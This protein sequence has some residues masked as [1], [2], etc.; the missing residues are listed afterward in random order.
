MYTINHSTPLKKTLS[1]L[2]VYVLLLDTM[3]PSIY[4][5]KT[6]S[7]PNPTLWISNHLSYTPEEE[8]VFQKEDIKTF[9][10]Q[11]SSQDLVNE[12]LLYSPHFLAS[13]ASSVQPEISGFSIG[14]SDEMVDKFTGDFSYSIPLVDVEGYPITLT[15]NSNVSMLDEASW[16]G[17]GWNLNVGSISRDMRGIPDDFNGTDIITREFSQRDVETT[18]SKNGGYVSVG[19]KIGENL[20]VGLG[21]SFLAGKYTDNYLGIGKTYDLNIGGS[22][23]YSIQSSAESGGLFLAPTIN[24]GMAYDSKNGIGSTFGFGLEAGYNNG[25]KSQ[26]SGSLSYN[27]S[28]HSRYGMTN[29]SLSVSGKLGKT[30][31]TSSTPVTISSSFTSTSNF[32]YGTQTSMPR[33]HLN[34]AT[35]SS[36][37]EL[38]IYAGLNVGVLQMR[39]GYLRQDYN[40]SSQILYHSGKKIFHPAYGYFHSGKRRSYSGSYFPMMDFNRGIENEYSEEMRNLP[41]SVQTHDVFYVNAKGINAVFR[42]MRSDYGTYYDPNSESTFNNDSQLYSDDDVSTLATGATFSIPLTIGFGI[43]YSSATM[44]AN[45]ASGNWNNGGNLLEFTSQSPSA[46]FDQPVYFK[47]MGGVAPVDMEPWNM[48]NGNTADYFDINVSGTQM[49]QDNFLKIKNSNVLSGALNAYHQKTYSDIYFK[50]N[51]AGEL[52]A[53]GMPAK[54]GSYFSVTLGTGGTSTQIKR[55]DPSVPQ[56]KA[57][58]ISLI[59]VVAPNGVSYEYGIPVYS[60][61]KEEVTFSCEGRPEL[62]ENTVPSGIVEYQNLDNSTNNNLGRAAYYDKTEFPAYSQA[63]L[64]TNVTSSDYVDLTDNG[65]TMDDPGNYYNF[66]HTRVYGPSNR[67]GTRFPI[68]GTNSSNKK[69]FYAKGA[70][71]STRDDLA[72]YTYQEGELWYT[73]AVESKNLIVEFHLEDRKDAYSAN[74]DGILDDS[75][76]MKLLSEIVVYN[77]TGLLSTDRIIL[78]TI[79]FYYDYSLCEKSPGNLNTYNGSGQPSGKLTLR[80]I[81]V[82]NGNSVENALSSIKFSY[83]SGDDNPDFS[84][85]DVDAWGQYKPNTVIKPN[86]QYPYSAQDRETADLGAKAWKLIAIHNPMGGRIEIDY[87]SDS[88]AYVQDRRAMRNFDVHRMTDLFDFLKIRKNGNWGG[89]YRSNGSDLMEKKFHHDYGNVANLL[90]KNGIPLLYGPLI[91][92]GIFNKKPT[93]LYNAVFGE[94]DIRMVPNNVIIFKLENPLVLSADDQVFADKYVADC[95]FRDTNDLSKGPIKEL[96]TKMYVKI[97]E[98]VYDLVPAMSTISSNYQMDIFN[99]Y[100]GGAIPE[101]FPPYGAMPGINGRYE[102]GYVVVDPVHT[103]KREEKDGTNKV[104][105]GTIA[106]NPMQLAALEYARAALVDKVYGSDPASEGDMSID[107]KVFYGNDM[108]K[109]MIEA[110]YCNTFDTD[111]SDY[112][113]LMRLNEPDYTKFGGGARVK[114]IR[115]FDNWEAISGEYDS[116][117]SWKYRYTEGDQRNEY[118][119]GVAAFEPMNMIDENPFNEWI[120]YTNIRKKFPDENK[121]IP[122][123]LAYQLF[124]KPVVGYSKVDVEFIEA[125]NYGK[126]TTLYYTARD[127]PTIS[128][129][130]TIDKSAKIK[131]NNIITGKVRDIYGITQGYVVE[132]NDFHGKLRTAEVFKKNLQNQYLPI[133]KT[134]YNY[135]GKGEQIKMADRSGKLGMH[136]AAIEY[137]I[138]ADSK[139]CT[140]E[141]R[142][143]EL[144][145]DFKLNWTPPI[146]FSLFFKPIFAMSSRE[147]AFYS[148][149]LVKHINYS[150]VVKDVVT[151]YLGSVNTARTN[152][153]DMYSGA[154]VVSELTDEYNDKLYQV[155]YPSHWKFKELRELHEVNGLTTTV[156]LASNGT[157]I[158]SVTH[159]NDML[160]PGDIV[161]IDGIQLYVAQQV[162]FP[163][164]GQLFFIRP[165]GTFYKPGAGPKTVQI[166]R[167]A[168][169][170]RLLETMQGFTTKVNPAA[171]TFISCPEDQILSASAISYRDRLTAVCNSCEGLTPGTIHNPY[172]YGMRGN[173][174]LDKQFALQSERSLT[175]PHGIR[176]D[177]AYR[178]NNPSDPNFILFYEGDNAGKWHAI[179]SSLHSEY[180]VGIDNQYN[181]WRPM[182]YSTVIDKHAHTMEAKDQL[183][184]YSAVLRGPGYFL[185]SLVVAQAVNAKREQIA[186]DGFEDYAIPLCR[187]NPGDAHFDFLNPLIISG[188]EGGASIDT[189]IRHSGLSSMRLEAGKTLSTANSIRSGDGCDP[190]QIKDP[191]DPFN[192]EGL[193]LRNCGC[194]STFSP[195]EGKYI[196]GAWIKGDHPNAFIEVAVNGGS[197]TPFYPQGVEIDGW[198]RVE[199]EFTIPPGATGITVSLKNTDTSLPAFFDDIRIH[200]FL[201]GMQTTVYDLKT[202]LP[203]ATHDGYNFTTFY[204]YDENLNLVRVRVETTEGIKTVMEQESGGQKSYIAD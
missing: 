41:F 110:G 43:A 69:A 119:N 155:N 96:Y 101:R 12:T 33:V 183:K 121:F 130:T 6:L 11:E 196:V 169:D 162:P 24:W 198:K 123:P 112:R 5:M 114:E 58:H 98:G 148:H 21:V 85:A 9:L 35:N 70:L 108:Y 159:S 111:I 82:F 75:K 142:F 135:Y 105:K 84:Y 74:Q 177:G 189:T 92:Y 153:F 77:K 61:H 154:P 122:G 27:R 36:N 133:S 20:G 126:S 116:Q 56:K 72:N 170:N 149:T 59:D 143:F 118:S 182:G 151:E 42:G 128:K 192:Q 132:T 10:E 32:S 48:V 54:Y 199:G 152:V 64:L 171:G 187:T 79:R 46:A 124:P 83:A 39:L 104:K 31:S 4:A 34:N 25:A 167:S 138:H 67:Y 109:Y 113:S 144:G 52:T 76:P 163:E 179:N 57:N 137:D 38:D 107:W 141:N 180:T 178:T 99:G 55:L 188:P 136:H 17:L 202:F 30:F 44:K 103:G 145:L 185:N 127:Y 14:S 26:M 51:T 146:F 181:N 160:T 176:F 172:K 134:V 102:Y 1:I 40:S 204:N 94:F 3:V 45:Q 164:N 139:Y 117:Y 87:E 166:I 8:P 91:A 22:A 184:I 50:P 86:D 7:A 125:S 23:R 66:F 62:T 88:Y 97:K 78:Q 186:F 65:P 157:F 197:T 71:G 200:P 100:F 115:Y 158:P 63:F 173:L 93:T 18:G 140:D 90:T 193:L 53:S 174:V 195:G 49:E 131:K 60:Y 190:E 28:K 175:D 16:V 81:R 129:S 161:V 89:T 68:S 13:M 80:E 168:R 19:A 120:T 147:R 156:T 29:S 73:A 203:L 106:I 194:A 47:P 191:S 95:Y 165:N 15:Y 201:A 37:F 150:A 2:L